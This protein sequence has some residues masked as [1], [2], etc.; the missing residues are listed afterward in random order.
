MLRSDCT[1]T[2][3]QGFIGRLAVYHG[4][5]KRIKYYIKL[6]PTAHLKTNTGAA[7]DQKQPKTTFNCPSFLSQKTK[8]RLF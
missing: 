2:Q 4:V 7:E 6:H 8:K 5:G 3:P 1:L